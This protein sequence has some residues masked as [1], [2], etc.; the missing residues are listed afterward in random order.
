MRHESIRMLSPADSS[1]SM[2][3]CSGA[4]AGNL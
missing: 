4:N 1:M 3:R 2:T